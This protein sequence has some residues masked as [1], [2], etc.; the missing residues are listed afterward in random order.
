MIAVVQFTHP[1]GEHRLNRQEK[2]TGVKEWNYGGH[3]RK[4][5][6]ANGSY[7]DHSG[8]VI[9]NKDLLFWGEWE[10][11]STAQSLLTKTIGAGVMPTL[12]H[13]PYLLIDQQGKA[14]APWHNGKYRTN[15]GQKEPCCRQNTDPFVFDDSFIYCCCKQR[16]R[17][18]NSH[19]T[20]LTKM[21]KLDKGSIILFG[22]TIS[23]IYFVLDT[24][25]VVGDSRIYTPRTYQNDLARFIPKYYEEIMGFANWNDPD[26]QFVCYK[27]ATL[28]NQ[29]NGMYSFA[30]CMLH[31]GNQINGFPRVRINGSRIPGIITNNLFAAPKFTAQP[32]LYN[33]KSIWDDIVMQVEAQGFLKGISFK[34]AVKTQP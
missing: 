25:F 18:K 26:N 21:G 4:F 10:P 6:L 13:E 19:L 3:K 8:S 27:G 2:K 23:K 29:V 12:V 11:T 20:T 22:S 34:Y 28:S 16:K 17:M 24:V 31:N 5:M 9:K 33:A 7:V 14:A 15:K 30:P 32:D 1:G